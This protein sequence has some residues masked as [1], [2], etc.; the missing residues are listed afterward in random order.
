MTGSTLPVPG[1]AIWRGVGPTGAGVSASLA[2]RRSTALWPLVAVHEAR[3][4]LGERL[5][6]A[7]G[8]GRRIPRR[9]QHL[10]GIDGNVDDRSARDSRAPGPSP[11]RSPGTESRTGLLVRDGHGV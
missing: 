1:A 3:D 4:L 10:L 8:A 2:R 11:P 7:P 5:D 6:L 9:H